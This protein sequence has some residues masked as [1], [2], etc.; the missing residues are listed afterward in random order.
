MSQGGLVIKNARGETI[1]DGLSDIGQGVVTV[2]TKLNGYQYATANVAT[3]ANT[4]D[5]DAIFRVWGPYWMCPKFQ[6]AKGTV[7]ICNP[8]PGTFPDGC[9]IEVMVLRVGSGPANYTGT[10]YGFVSNGDK[11]NQI[12][13][14]S[15]RILRWRSGAGINP[16]WTEKSG[17]YSDWLWTASLD[18]SGFNF[19]E[20]PYVFL[21]PIRSL[22]AQYGTERG[23]VNTLISCTTTTLYI[24]EYIIQTAGMVFYAGVGSFSI[25]LYSL[26][27]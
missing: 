19:K 15:S 20:T 22:D 25:S 24:G 27:V 18:I 4:L 14:A 17:A 5:M 10:N 3:W 21:S 11:G 6:M 23:R 2:G 9:D 16:S 13:N 8:F 26:G 7:Y 1:T 12:L